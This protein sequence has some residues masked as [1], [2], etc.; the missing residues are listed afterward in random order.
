[1]PISA[2]A[3]QL[4]FDLDLPEE[5]SNS[6]LSADE[7]RI[8]SEAARHEL[9]GGTL[10]PSTGQERIVPDWYE[11]YLKLVAGGWYWRAAA[12]VAWLSQPK[13]R[14]PKT[15]EELAKM[16]GLSSDRQFSVWRA[17][18]PAIDAQVRDM[19]YAMVY[20]DLGEVLAA[21]LSVA[22]EHDYKG[23]GDR[24]MIYK[25]AGILTDKIEAEVSSKSAADL[26][27]LSW[28]EKLHLAG[29][30]NPEALMALKKKLSEQQPTF[31]AE[32]ESA[33]GNQD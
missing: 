5:E 3:Y 15:Q 8:R 6:A 7:I 9:E 32:D 16:L 1:M 30:D 20:E 33:D 29:L 12:L 19:R 23:R 21:G 18:N 24:E 27:K 31:E 17:K 25:M 22:K 11:K 13:P 10:W 2:P 28:E 14:F 26:S 4:K